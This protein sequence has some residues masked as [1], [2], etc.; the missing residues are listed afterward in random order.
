MDSGLVPLRQWSI[1]GAA[2][3]MFLASLLS[4]LGLKLEHGK[5]EQRT[6]IGGTDEVWVHSIQHW[7]GLDMLSI[8][9]AFTPKLPLACL[10]G[11]KGFLNSTGSRLIQSRILRKW[12]QSA[13]TAR[14]PRPT[15]ISDTTQFLPLLTSSS[16]LQ[17]GTSPAE[18]AQDRDVCTG[19]PMPRIQ[20][21]IAHS[22][23]DWANRHEIRSCS[24][25]T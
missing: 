24:R 1:S 7:I 6:G 14:D 18:I 3:C 13:S 17:V 20:H 11:R 9:A 16:S 5:K 21:A 25:R 22:S 10:P 15:R 8:D 12:S 19:A 23:A 2:D 4:G